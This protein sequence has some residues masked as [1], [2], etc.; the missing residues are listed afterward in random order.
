MAG[1][2]VPWSGECSSHSAHKTLQYGGPIAKAIGLLMAGRPE[3][4]GTPEELWT[5]LAEVDDDFFATKEEWSVRPEIFTAAL[6]EFEPKLAGTDL[7]IAWVDDG[8]ILIGRM[9]SEGA[10]RRDFL[11]H[12]NSRGRAFNTAL[13]P[14]LVRVGPT[15]G[16]GVAR[17]LQRGSPRNSLQQI[18]CH[19]VR[20]AA[21]R[22][23]AS[24]W[25]SYGVFGLFGVYGCSGPPPPRIFN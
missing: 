3:W 16:R 15:Q 8:R 7:S 10:E 1:G 20:R 11:H 25:V 17:D 4:I 5:A 9:G 24:S 12:R 14:R 19:N 22:R 6:K 13:V 23:N 18:H 21:A 2:P